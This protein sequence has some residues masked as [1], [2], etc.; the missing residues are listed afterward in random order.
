MRQGLPL[1]LMWCFPPTLVY[2]QT[3]PSSQPP[4]AA[5]M[6]HGNS[7][8]ED[9]VAGLFA[10][11]R[12][13]A[14]LHKLGRIKDRRELQQLVCTV[15]LTGKVPRFTNGTAVLNTTLAD[16]PSALYETSNPGEATPELRQVALFERPRGRSGHTPGHRRYSVAVWPAQQEKDREPEYW[17]GVELFW[18]A[19]AEFFLNHFSDAME[20]KN[21]WKHF[22]APQC[23]DAK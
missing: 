11:A 18:S 3:V 1:L 8:A 4:K 19:G 21:E 6:L 7:Q 23:K 5:L 10:T 9:E 20:W 22:V 12:K 15:S 14:K 13:D 16:R 2:A 17:V